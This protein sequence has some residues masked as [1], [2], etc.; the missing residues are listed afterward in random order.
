MHTK[1]KIFYIIDGKNY[2]SEIGGY[3]RC[4]MTRLGEISA[5]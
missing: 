4:L 3:T 5:T 1:G 2:Y